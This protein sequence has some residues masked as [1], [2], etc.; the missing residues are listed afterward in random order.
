MKIFFSATTGGWYFDSVHGTSIPPDSKEVSNAVYQALAGKAVIGDADGMP[1][2]RPPSKF[3]YCASTGCFYIDVVHGDSIPDDAKEVSD[4]VYQALAGRDV[5]PDADG[6]PILRPAPKFFFSATTGGFY[7]DA[8]N[9]ATLPEDAKEISRQMYESLI[10]CDVVADGE[11]L[12]ILRPASVP[13]AIDK[14][15]ALKV[16]ATAK[17]YAV[18]TGGI[19]LPNGTR[20]D[21][22]RED[23]NAVANAI[24]L[25]GIAGVTEV[26]FKAASGWLTVTIPTLT[27]IGA[28]IGLHKQA[29]YTAERAHHEAIDALPD[30]GLDAYDLEAAWPTGADLVSL[31]APA[32]LEVE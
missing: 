24:S 19:E 11:G 8:A 16:A 14:R 13:T 1:I 3:F 12:P 21:T 9:S 31:F 17:R 30:S 6:L 7:S 2:L 20:L 26:D 15:A 4:E 25:A 29:C 22:T 32:A 27:R 5:V 18:E 10:G 28:A 23:Q